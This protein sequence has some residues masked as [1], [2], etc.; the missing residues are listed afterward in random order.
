MASDTELG[1]WRDVLVRRPLPWWQLLQSAALH[2]AIVA[3]LW[4]V[5]ISWLRQ[6]KILV[7]P[8]FDR[9]SVLTYTPQEYLPPLDTGLPGPAR[10]QKGDP[11]YAKQ[12]ILSVPREADNR[13]QTIVTPPDMRLTRDVALPNIV[14]MAV[15]VPAVPLDALESP[16][17]KLTAPETAVIA[18]APELD[19]TRNHSAHDPLNNSVVAPAPDVA[20]THMRGVA[21]SEVAV[22]APAPEL[23]RSSSRIGDL[24]VAPSAVIAPAPQLVVEQQHAR[25]AR[26]MESMPGGGAEPVAPPPS[27]NGSLGGQSGGRLI[28]LSIQPAAITGSVTPPAGNRRGTFSAG[29]QGKS[30]ASGTPEQKGPS[31][32]TANGLDHTSDGG[33]GGERARNGS[34]PAGLRVGAMDHG[35]S[36]GTSTDEDPGLIARATPARVS[37]RAAAP[38]EPE[39]ATELDRKVFGERRFYSMTL[40]MPN[41]NSATGSWVI[42]F[43][44]FEATH[45]DGELTAP[46]P[47]QKSDPGYPTELRRENV[48]GTVTLYAVIHSDGSVG[49]IRVLNSPD[50]RLDAFASN[51]LA[52]WKFRPATKNGTPVALEA[53]VKIPFQLKRSF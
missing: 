35:A 44:E 13:R 49:D 34:L 11:V 39:K 20:L 40:N 17:K 26:G 36:V 25:A 28:A 48:Q 37:V 24:N 12:P 21:G 31:S 32:S 53:V 9:S 3:L 6:Q 43:A 38:V 46:D 18:P 4:M 19:S 30:G 5:S 27:L 22:V 14:S 1:R 50:D 52:R 42:R 29:P 15:P 7:P 47:T 8:Q 51:A 41:L 2:L 10:R 45:R 33:S 23:P 16:S